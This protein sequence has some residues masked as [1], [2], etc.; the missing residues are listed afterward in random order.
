MSTDPQGNSSAAEP[1]AAEKGPEVLEPPP[2]PPASSEPE[3]PA[4]PPSAAAEGDVEMRTED[5]LSSGGVRWRSKRPLS[6]ETEQPQSAK[7]RR[8]GEFSVCEDAGQ[9]EES[10]LLA[11]E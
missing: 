5:P 1:A 10:I 6:V 3:P 7:E 9:A 11:N 2:Q 8:L 4:A